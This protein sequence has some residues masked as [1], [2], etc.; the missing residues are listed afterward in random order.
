MRCISYW[1]SETFMHNEMLLYLHTCT[2]CV[3]V[4]NVKDQLYLLYFQGFS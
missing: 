1:Q 4:C 2:V 3:C